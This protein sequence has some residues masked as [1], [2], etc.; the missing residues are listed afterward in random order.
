[1]PIDYNPVYADHYFIQEAFELPPTVSKTEQVQDDLL[2]QA[3]EFAKNHC[4]S[5]HAN[6][7]LLLDYIKD[8]IYSP[9]YMEDPQTY[10]ENWRIRRGITR[11]F[12]IPED[13]AKAFFESINSGSNQ[14]F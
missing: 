9:E 14:Q 3:E 7:D 12:R 13:T 6:Y 2:T 5:N 10:L 11:E 4:G 8:V 1:M